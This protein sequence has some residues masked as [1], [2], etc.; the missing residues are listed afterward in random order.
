LYLFQID[1]DL[2]I[3]KPL[4]IDNDVDVI[5]Y[6]KVSFSCTCNRPQKTPR[7]FHN[8]KEI[9]GNDERVTAV[10]KDYEH[11][12]IIHHVELS[13]EGEYMVVFDRVTSKTS[14]KVK[15]KCM[16]ICLILKFQNFTS[17]CLMLNSA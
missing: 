13:D 12:L 14:V 7:W 11:K 15:G 4:Q 9:E 3:I 17:S 5:Q 2:H 8:N 1:Q 16:I 6:M 10:S